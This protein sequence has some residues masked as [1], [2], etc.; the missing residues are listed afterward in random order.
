MPMPRFDDIEVGD[1]LP[2]LEH[3][4]IDRL[5]LALYAGASGDHNPMHVDIDFVKKAGLDDVFAHGM[6]GM[7]W[8]GRLVTQW[9]PQTAL[10]NLDARFLD[11]VPVH[12]EVISRGRVARKFTEEGENRIEVEIENVDGEGKA[13][14]SGRAVI[15]LD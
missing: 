15:A 9:V 2:A 12:A 1:D 7:A 13:S 11:I 8:L 14:I 6:L 10:R 4:P 5:Q 3:P